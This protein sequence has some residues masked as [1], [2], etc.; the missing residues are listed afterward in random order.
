[1]GEDGAA[2]PAPSTVT[3]DPPAATAAPVAGGDDAAAC[4]APSTVTVDAPAATATGAAPPPADGAA[5]PPAAGGA[6]NNVQTF[7]G[8]LG[9]APPAVNNVGGGRP[10][11]VNGNTFVNAGAA[12]QRS[13]AI[14]NNACANAVNS[15]QLSLPGGVSDCNKQESECNAAAAAGA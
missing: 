9:G 7:T 15:K 8:A 4:P 2:C 1:M 12:L 3:V 14:Q 5:T 6:G 10:F 13:C 11:E